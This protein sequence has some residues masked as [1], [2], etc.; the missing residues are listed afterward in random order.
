MA[1]V[2]ITPIEEGIVGVDAP[3]LDMF[4]VR[5][6]LVYGERFTLL[7]DTLARPVD[8]E[9]VREEVERR[10]KPLLIVNSHA[11]WDH[12][13]GNEAFPTAPVIAHR[14]TLERQRREGREEL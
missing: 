9:R 12:W 5:A 3:C 2:Q 11:D 1:E 8:L 14:P 10:G 7:I 6:L 4:D 13:W